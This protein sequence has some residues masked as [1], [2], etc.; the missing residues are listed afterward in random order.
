MHYGKGLKNDDGVWAVSTCILLPD[1]ACSRRGSFPQKAL[2]GLQK[3]ECWV[4]FHGLLVF[5]M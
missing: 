1:S 2:Q 5:D 3:P 4:T